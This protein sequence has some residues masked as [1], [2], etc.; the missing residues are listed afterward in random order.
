MDV[1]VKVSLGSTI[2]VA[3]NDASSHPSSFEVV[4]IVKSYMLLAES[5]VFRVPEIVAVVGLFGSSR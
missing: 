2:I 1:N 4:I 3:L 5:P